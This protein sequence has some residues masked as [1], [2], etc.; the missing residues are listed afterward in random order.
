MIY[1]LKKMTIKKKPGLGVKINSLILKN[2]TILASG[3]LGQDIE[4]MKRV[5]KGGAGAVTMKS[6]TSLPRKGHNNP[7]L[8]EVESGF[9]NAVGYANKGIDKGIQEFKKWNGAVPMVG[10]IVGADARELAALA[11]K[12]QTL[13]IQALEVALSCPHTPGFGLLAGQGTAAATQEITKAIRK[14]TKLPLIIKLSPSVPSLG[15]I[16]KTAEAE[17]ADVVNMGNTL[18]PG[19]KIDIER[20]RPVLAFKVGGMSGP[21]IK[22][23]MIRCVFDIYQAVKIPVIATGGIMSGQDAIEAIMA[24]ATAV[25][26]GTGIYYRGIGIFKKITKEMENWLTD[27]GYEN[28]NQLIGLAH[29][30]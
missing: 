27:H 17:G 30:S 2:P 19:M 8:V 5:V 28:I 6:L 7:I 22:P 18:G 25:G 29:R 4:T 12:I 14:K 11:E 23:V 20:G 26:I 24:G 21:A 9:L 16:A 3:V 1:P 13:P 15:E 10:S